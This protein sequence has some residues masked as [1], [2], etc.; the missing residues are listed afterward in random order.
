MFNRFLK[1]SLAALA[2][3]GL[4]AVVVVSAPAASAQVPTYAPN[5][6]R[7]QVPRSSPLWQAQEN[8]DYASRGKY[9]YYALAQEGRFV[10]FEKGH[11]ECAD[12]V[13]MALVSGNMLPGNTTSRDGHYTWGRPVNPKTEPVLPGDIIQLVNV[14]LSFKTA[15]SWGTWETATQHTAII[16]SNDKLKLTVVEQNAPLGSP[17]KKGGVINLNWTKERGDWQIYRPYVRPM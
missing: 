10:D 4:M 17:V 2:A 12:F 3:P 6:I 13:Q 5:D 1:V 14:K 15:N 11:H 7:L 8:L 9:L 16:I